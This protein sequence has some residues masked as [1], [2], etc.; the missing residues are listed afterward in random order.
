MNP[1]KSH[2]IAD[3][4]CRVAFDVMDGNGWKRTAQ[5]HQNG[6]GF[7]SMTAGKHRDGRQRWNEMEMPTRRSK[8]REHWEVRF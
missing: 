5:W 6:T 3:M 1:Q 8:A 4:R 2:N 7:R